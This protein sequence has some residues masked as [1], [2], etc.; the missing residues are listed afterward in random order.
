MRREN[1]AGPVIGIEMQNDA[2][3]LRSNV[4]LNA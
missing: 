3:L 1:K 2:G 4:A